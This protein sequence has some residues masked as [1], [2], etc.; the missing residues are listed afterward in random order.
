MRKSSKTTSLRADVVNPSLKEALDQAKSE[1]ESNMKRLDDQHA[2]VLSLEMPLAILKSNR[3]H[4]MINKT[5]EKKCN[6][7]KQVAVLTPKRKAIEAQEK[8]ILEL[9]ELHKHLKSTEQDF[10]KK[11]RIHDADLTVSLEN[12]TSKWHEILIEEKAL[13]QLKQKIAKTHKALTDTK[14]TKSQRDRVSEQETILEQLATEKKVSKWATPSLM[15]NLMGFLSQKEK[16]RLQDYANAEAD[17]NHRFSQAQEELLK[18]K[19]KLNEHLNVDALPKNRLEDEQNLA[20]AKLAEM[21][22]DEIS[23]RAML[24]TQIDETLQ[25]AK[26]K[27]EQLKQD[28]EKEWNNQT[29][30][31]EEKLIS[32]KKV[33]QQLKKDVERCHDNVN[34]LSKKYREFCE[35]HLQITS[36]MTS[37][38]HDTAE[39]SLAEA[40]NQFIESKHTLEDWNH[41]KHVMQEHPQAK[42]K[43]N[44]CIKKLKEIYPEIFKHEANL[45]YEK[46]MKITD[47]AVKQVAGCFTLNLFPNQKDEKTTDA[48]APK[49]TDEVTDRSKT[50]DQD[51]DS[52]PG[53]IK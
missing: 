35:L 15:D 1:H 48:D 19:Q 27:L 47:K 29:H 3:H 36:L 37:N 7:T 17:W 45:A 31:V 8:V 13:S 34:D 18:A 16:Q 38:H 12:L 51:Q 9:T 6:L 42:T 25:A 44:S 5:E 43:L 33:V 21:K 14:A 49:T 22:H 52:G 40:L 23:T 28:E 20:E 11:L 26:D 2:V 30:I 50:E 32:A 46:V 41:V 39:K 53:K 4:R 24:I 10:K